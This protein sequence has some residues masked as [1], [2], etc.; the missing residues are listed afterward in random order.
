MDTILILMST[1]QGE[2]Y[3]A[4]QLDSIIAQTHTQWRLLIRDDGSTD[5]TVD[6]IKRYVERDARIRLMADDL[7]N[8]KPAQSFSVL[9]EKALLEKEPFICF[10]DQDDVW[11]EEKLSLQ[12]KALK[13]LEEIHGENIPLLVF[14]DL[15][16]VDANLSTIHPS[17]LKF[18]KLSANLVSSL[19]T[20]LIY[21]YVTGCAAAM[22]RALLAL[23][24]PVPEKALMHDWWCALCAASEGKLG[25][26]E[27]ATLYYRQHEKNDSGS[28][29][30]YSK[31]KSLK[32]NPNSL[33][34]RFTQAKKLLSR[35]NKSNPHF[36]L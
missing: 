14:S 31:L 12:V 5:G 23:A 10:A 1:Y 19:Q 30:F 18:E 16:V 6:I 17:Y 2:Q 4:A 11:R 24:T 29:G 28:K 25:F 8:L 9:M 15:C 27:Q 13:E 33:L 34:K 21:N 22:N 35:M 3:L 26:I 20:L 32:L 36:S 7:G